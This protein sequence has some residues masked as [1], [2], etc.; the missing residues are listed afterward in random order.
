MRPNNNIA[1]SKITFG[2]YEPELLYPNKSS[3]IIW[4][5]RII[6]G[7]LGAVANFSISMGNLTFQN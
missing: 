6:V 7:D 5:P 3:E 2:G 1:N 4:A